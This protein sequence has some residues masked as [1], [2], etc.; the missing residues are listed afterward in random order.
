MIPRMEGPGASQAPMRGPLLALLSVAALGCASSPSAPATEADAALPPS[1]PSTLS[2][3][4]APERM[5]LLD[6]VDFDVAGVPQLTE[7]PL[8]KLSREAGRAALLVLDGPY[9]KGV[10]GMTGAEID[11]EGMRFFVQAGGDF[12][13]GPERHF[14]EP[15]RVAWRG[16]VAQKPEGLHVVCFEGALDPV[17]GTVAAKAAYEVVARPLVPD[18]VY[19]L[20]SGRRETGSFRVPEPHVAQRERLDGCVGADRIEVFGPSPLWMSSSELSPRDAKSLA[21]RTFTTRAGCPFSRV[22]ADI[23]RGTISV[24]HFVAD[25]PEQRKALAAPV[26]TTAFSY[27]VEVDAAADGAHPVGHLFVGS[28]NAPSERLTPPRVTEY[29]F[30]GDEGYLE[31]LR[32]PDPSAE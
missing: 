21:C 30:S 22:S 23:E 11:L 3:L 32:E 18:L 2:R 10:V 5:K 1:A 13:G 6:R 4:E 26:G 16:I 14:V 7:V 27:T 17:T 15:L 20:R 25:G 31:P 19:A 28:T 24:A 9:A 29:Y 8:E 12:V